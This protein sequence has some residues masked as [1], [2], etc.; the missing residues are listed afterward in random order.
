[1]H[2]FVAEVKHT[3]PEEREEKETGLGTATLT[4][5]EHPP[6]PSRRRRQSKGETHDEQLSDDAS[7]DLSENLT[8]EESVEVSLSEGLLVVT[9]K[10]A[11]LEGESLAA[12]LLEVDPSYLANTGSLKVHICSTY[13]YILLVS[14]LFEH[15]YMCIYKDIG[16]LRVIAHQLCKI[17]IV[18]GKFIMSYQPSE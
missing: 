3:I 6:K 11:K 4:E 17:Y 15:S 8:L 9:E 12:E 5:A 2:L 13:V 10:P 16:D 14:C 18:M 7:S 1:M